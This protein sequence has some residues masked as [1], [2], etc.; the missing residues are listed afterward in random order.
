MSDTPKIYTGQ[1]YCGATEVSVLGEPLA[2]GYCHCKSCQSFHGA[3][4]IRWSVWPSDAVTVNGALNQ[5]DKNPALARSTCASCGGKMMGVLTEAGMTVVF[6]NVLTDSG[7]KF[8]PQM[9]KYYGERVVDIVDGVPKF[10]DGPVEFGGNGRTLH[11]VG[12]PRD[13]TG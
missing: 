1:C 2:S 11:E 10:E 7:L 8:K 3:P 6:P 12:E 9:H 4:F 13:S 5:T